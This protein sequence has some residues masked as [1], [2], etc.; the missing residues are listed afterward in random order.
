MT[1]HS[2]ARSHA[3]HPA[4][5]GASRE[6][7]QQGLGLIVGVMCGDDGIK[8]ALER[9]FPE[10]LISGGARLLLNRRSG[11][12]SPGGSKDSVGHTQ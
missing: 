4:H 2:R 1:G 8:A 11:W 3:G 9:P 12:A 7:H 10:R 5:S 6:A